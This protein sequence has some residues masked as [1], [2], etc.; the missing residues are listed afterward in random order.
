MC[1][2]VDVFHLYILPSALPFFLIIPLHSHLYGVPGGLSPLWLTRTNPSLK[3]RS[4]PSIFPCDD[5]KLS[6]NL[7]TSSPF[8]PYSNSL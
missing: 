3:L 5:L 6:P 7:L 4:S 8:I 1:T 2:K